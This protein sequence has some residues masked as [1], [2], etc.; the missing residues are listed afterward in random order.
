MVSPHAPSARSR[1]PERSASGRAREWAGLLAT[2]EAETQALR[3]E[4]DLLRTQVRDA[5]CETAAA[6][7]RATEAEEKLKTILPTLKEVAERLRTS[8]EAA[9]IESCMHCRVLFR[10][11]AAEAERRYEEHCPAAP[12]APAP[13]P[14]TT[15]ERWAQFRARSGAPGRS[16]TAVCAAGRAAEREQ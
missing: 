10:D 7:R 15:A 4:V 14:T 9:A 3:Q 12:P 2:Q 6:E 1:Y 13:R 5:K 8:P 16:R 11:L